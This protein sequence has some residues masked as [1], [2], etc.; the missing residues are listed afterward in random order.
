MLLFK[1]RLFSCDALSPSERE[2]L[3]ALKLDQKIIKIILF[4]GKEREQLVEKQH[5][6][7]Q[8]RPNSRC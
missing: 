1:A 7:L 5:S 8:L 3:I 2:V 4:H 6:S